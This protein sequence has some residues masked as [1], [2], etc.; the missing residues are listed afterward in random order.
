MQV[1]ESNK[2]YCNSFEEMVMKMS[3]IRIKSENQL[4]ADNFYASQFN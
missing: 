4:F 2:I 1:K 3:F